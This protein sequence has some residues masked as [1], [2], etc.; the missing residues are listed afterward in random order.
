VRDRV[1]VEWSLNCGDD[2]D[3][4]EEGKYFGGDGAKK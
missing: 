2:D 3:V 4:G 1:K